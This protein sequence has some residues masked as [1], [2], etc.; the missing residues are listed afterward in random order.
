MAVKG[1]GQTVGMAV[2]VKT[3]E[4]TT[5]VLSEGSASQGGMEEVAWEGKM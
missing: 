1:K 3:V 4:G 5:V 2:V